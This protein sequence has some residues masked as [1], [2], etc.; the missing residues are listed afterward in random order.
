MFSTTCNRWTCHFISSLSSLL[1]SFFFF[2][3]RICLYCFILI[4]LD[5]MLKSFLCPSGFCQ[6]PFLSWKKPFPVTYK[7]TTTLDFDSFISKDERRKDSRP[8]CFTVSS[9]WFSSAL[10]MMYHLPQPTTFRKKKVLT[11]KCVSCRVLVFQN[12]TIMSHF[13]KVIDA[14]QCLL[15]DAVIFTSA[16]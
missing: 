9:V 16:H 15:P 11:Q 3:F 10:I 8:P 5:F 13:R 14:S 2:F 7:L 4:N 1:M 12:R 6:V